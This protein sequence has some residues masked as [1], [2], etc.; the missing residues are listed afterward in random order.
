M[1]RSRHFSSLLAGVL[2]TATLLTAQVPVLAAEPASGTGNLLQSTSGSSWYTEAAEDCT[3][4][5]LINTGYDMRFRPDEPM[6]RAQIA[7]AFYGAVGTPELTGDLSYPYE[8]VLPIAWYTKGI[9]WAWKQQLMQGYSQTRFGPDDPV[10]REQFAVILW[11]F[12]GSPDPVE[13][14]KGQQP[15]APFPDED[16]IASWAR[17]AVDWL[18]STGLV[19]GTDSGEFIPQSICTQAE[20]V[21]LLSRYFA[22]LETPAE[23]PDPEPEPEPE[24]VPEPEP[25]PQPEPQ[26][27]PPN[28]Y[29]A[30]NFTTSN[31]FLVYNDDSE[32]P[33][34]CYV[35]IDVSR[36][37]ETIDW[38]KVKAAGV[39]FAIIRAGYRGY[40]YGN[41]K[42]DATFRYN[43]ENAIANGIDVGVYFFSQAVTEAEAVEEA[44]QLLRWVENYE[45]TYP[46]VFDWEEVRQPGSRS[47]NL[48]GDVLT[49]CAVAFCR[50]I[51][52]AGYLPMTYGSPNKVYADLDLSRLQDWPFWLAH[53]TKNWKPTSFR[54][55][56]QIWQYSSTGT[57]PGIGPDVDL[58]I[59]LTDFHEY[60]S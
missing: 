37:Q 4:R 29:K 50:T 9:I 5:G 25:E 55:D 31:G 58:N 48:S 1:R 11:H 57:I 53:Y 26:P 35:G 32:D 45:I 24:P 43:I 14:A 8:D 60:R 12:L 2:A 33:V 36:Y 13:P 46:L 39:D 15:P 23:E 56:Y 18:H 28:P 10:T 27:I 52:K 6:T 3:R 21:V 30:E 16:R 19:I 22:Y 40:T 47:R 38:A 20:S 44:Q 17:D 54:Y 59:C 51:E 42:Q 41:I 49:R 34:P 7:V